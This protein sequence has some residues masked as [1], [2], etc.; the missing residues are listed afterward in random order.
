VSIHLI[1]V[2]Y[3]VIPKSHEYDD[4]IVLSIHVLAFFLLISRK[5][6]A[7]IGLVIFII[8]NVLEHVMGT[9][10]E[11]RFLLLMSDMVEISEENWSGF[12]DTLKLRIADSLFMA[13]LAYSSF[14]FKD[15]LA[16]KEET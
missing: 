11:Y 10:F 8:G 1:L 16:S 3:G 4:V 9:I 5:M 6:F 7:V 13:G 15:R 12:F 2:L 14:R